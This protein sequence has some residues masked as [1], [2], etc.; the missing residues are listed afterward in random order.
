MKYFIPVVLALLGA[1]ALV[2]CARKPLTPVTPWADLA[3]DSLSFFTTSTDPGAL[4]VC[5]VFDWGDGSTTTTDYFASGDT[6]YCVHGFDDTRVHNIRVRARNEKGSSSGWS[7]SLRFRLTQPPELADTIAGRPRWAVDRWY[8]ASVRVTDPDADSVAV[9]FVWGDLP[10]AG[11]SAYVPSGSIV[12]DSC[13]WSVIGPHTVSVV[14][15]DKGGTMSGSNAVKTVSVSKMAVLWTNLDD[16]RSYEATPTLGSISGQPVLYCKATDAVDC[17]GLDGRLRWRAPLSTASGYAASLNSDGSCLYLTDYDYGLVCLDAATGRQ[18][19]SLE[20]NE[21]YCTPA[22][23]PDGA[24]YVAALDSD[25]VVK[26]VNDC[27]DS[28]VVE[29]SVPVGYNG[30]ACGPVLDRNRV[31]YATGCD[32]LSGRSALVAIDADGTVLW[33]A[34]TPGRSGGS[35][36]IDSRNR[37][38][39]ADWQGYLTCFNPDGALAWSVLTNQLWPNCAAIGRDDQVIVTDVTGGIFSFD[40]AGR[41][42]WQTAD[43]VYGGNTPCVAQDGIIIAGDPE[44]LYGIDANT[45]LT[46]WE[47]S[48]WDSLEYAKRRASI[49]EGDGNPSVVVGP[50]GDLYLASWDGLFWVSNS[51]LRMANTAWPT[52]NHDNAHSGWAGR[53]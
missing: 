35:P 7:P 37:V 3:D 45:G 25:Y 22:I 29:W 51:D 14:L 41:Q 36:V 31:V 9:K 34:D 52:Y 40:S 39:I 8:H 24:V 26:R 1:L 6:G 27:G 10:A 30:Y 43:G 47:F 18:K 53:Q 12:S 23:G 2:S 50:A 4:Q 46:L 44:D 16:E 19:W 38:L 11:W 42:Q 21:G 20:L 15:R 49:A 33:R 17:Y 28:A 32:Y 48:A 5:Y 13:R